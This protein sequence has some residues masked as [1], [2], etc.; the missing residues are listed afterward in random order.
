MAIAEALASGLPCVV[1]GVMGA[2]EA[3]TDGCDGFVVPPREAEFQKRVE[4]L[5]EDKELRQTMADKAR[6][7]V[8]RLSREFIVSQLLELYA[9]LIDERDE[10]QRSRKSVWI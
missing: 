5:V 6:A 10:S 7:D 3:L 2:A 9:E 4:Q 8:H 1:V